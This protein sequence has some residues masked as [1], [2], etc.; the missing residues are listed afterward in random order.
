M[1]RSPKHNDHGYHDGH[2]LGGE[3]ESAHGKIGGATTTESDSYISHN[4]PT[5]DKKSG[6][7][8]SFTNASTIVPV[9]SSDAWTSGYP[10]SSQQPIEVRDFY[11]ITS[12]DAS[13]KMPN[14]HSAPTSDSFK[15]AFQDAPLPPPMNKSYSYNNNSQTNPHRPAQETYWQSTSDPVSPSHISPTH[16][17]NNPQPQAQ[18]PYPEQFNPSYP[19]YP[20]PPPRR[21]SSPIPYTYTHTHTHTDTSPNP[22]PNPYYNPPRTRTITASPSPTLPPTNPT[23]VLSHPRPYPHPPL[24]L[25]PLT[26]QTTTRPPQTPQTPHQAPKNPYFHPIQLDARAPHSQRFPRHSASIALRRGGEDCAAFT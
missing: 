8:S 14:R 19:T 24:P 18:N 11:G 5:H 25:L 17:E 4:D 7:Y 12:Q 10:A 6:I 3:H 21:S 15:T 2:D 26:P 1:D 20:G 23:T 22:N 9:A 13:Y 16:D